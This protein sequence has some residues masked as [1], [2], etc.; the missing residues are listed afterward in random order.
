MVPCRRHVDA[1]TLIQKRW[2]LLDGQSGPLGCPVAA[3][4]TLGTARSQLFQH[5]EIVTSPDQG[6]HMAV[7]VYQQEDNV[8]TSWGDSSAF[9]YD[10]W[11]VRW[12]KDGHYAGQQEINSY[13]D[14]T[15]GFARIQPFA[16]GTY[17]ASV[18]G[19]D[20]GATSSQ[21]RQGWTV[22][23]TVNYV[24]P[25]PLNAGVSATCPGPIIPSGPIR[26]RW[27]DLGGATGPLGCPSPPE[28][29]PRSQRF[30]HGQ[31]VWSP[32][33]GAQMAVAV[34]TER[35]DL[36]ADWGD[37]SPFNYDK[38]LVRWIKNGYE[39]GQQD[40]TDQTR[41]GGQ[42]RIHDPGSGSYVV[43]VEGCD[44]GGVSGSHCNQGWTAPVTLEYAS[45]VSGYNQPAS[46]PCAI[47]TASLIEQRWAAL[48]GQRGPLGCPTGAF[49]PPSPTPFSQT[50]ANGE[51][52]TSL[53]QG[54]NMVV[55]AYQ[56]GDNVVV[57]WG[58]STPFHY[59]KWL[60]RWYIDGHYADQTDITDQS[61]A[62]GVHSMYWNSSNTLTFQIEGCDTS[63]LTGSRCNQGWTTPAS[64]H[65]NADLIDLSANPPATTPQ[66]AADTLPQRAWAVSDYNAC[67]RG[68]ILG[69]INT[70][71]E[72]WTTTAFAML[73]MALAAHQFPGPHGAFQAGDPQAVKVGVNAS[74][75]VPLGCPGDYVDFR[76]EVN[77]AIRNQIITAKAGT[78]AGSPGCQRTGEYDTA[79]RGYITIMF[80]FHAVLDPDVRY[81][82]LHLLNKSGPY[83]AAE[84]DSPCKLQTGETENHLWQ[85]ESSRY[86]T[87]QL[88]FNAS[89][90]EGDIY[91]GYHTARYD[92]AANG[93]NDG[94]VTMKTVI[95]TMLQH[96]L[97][98]DFREYNSNPYQTYTVPSIL[99]LADD[100]TDAD[101]ATG[102]RAVLDYLSAKFAVSDNLL[103]RSVPYRR[104]PSHYTTDLLAANSDALKNDFMVLTGMTQ[105]LRDVTPPYHAGIGTETDMQE[106]AVSSYQ[107]PPLIM[108][109]IMNQAHRHFFERFKHDGVEIYSGEP[110]FLI[111]GGGIWTGASIAAVILGADASDDQGLALPTVLI[112]TQMPIVGAGLPPNT[113]TDVTNF[114][115]IDGVGSSPCH[116][117]CTDSG[118]PNPNRDRVMTCVTQDF[119][120]GINPVIPLSYLSNPACAHEADQ[121]VN[122]HVTGHWTFID[123][124]SSACIGAQPPGTDPLGFSVAVYKASMDGETTCQMFNGG[125]DTG[126][127][128]TYDG[129]NLTYG[130]FE[131][132]GV[133]EGSHGL[134]GGD[135][136]QS[137]WQTVLRNNDG[138]TFDPTGANTYRASDG[139][140]IQFLFNPPN[141][142][143]W[144]WPIVQDP[145]IG[146][147][148]VQQDISG[149]PLAKGNVIASDGHSGLV[150][151]TNADTNQELSL[152]FR[153]A[154]HPQVATRG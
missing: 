66:Q 90:A 51:I 144:V 17:G 15:V 63:T 95:L 61:P 8:I 128:G 56:R 153:D 35:G 45:N 121:T 34:Y 126:C 54:A 109:L 86:L 113:Y 81:R 4:Q 12:D 135:T 10:K 18:E 154:M 119:A 21:C 117:Q 1:N 33:Q 31:I 50:F 83:D 20:N 97:Q 65:F 123:R 125:V 142:N 53:N 77:D 13:V 82:I 136:F 115:R 120:C 84:D 80:R 26:D 78:S 132:R 131:A 7:A 62:G 87:N 32:Q 127:D 138:R 105:I 60:I 88:L 112:P 41:L 43:R 147:T 92:N 6:S 143:K 19:C 145:A 76:T 14:R 118:G 98:N 100:A 24:S 124:Q 30:S 106:M 73:A 23:A 130:F 102:A 42:W 111:S 134:P 47:A 146:I 107:P 40:I 58:D 89:T 49:P 99:N 74:G 64:V 122:D 52:V 85:I 129:T 91:A 152:D 93:M 149:W 22:R 5:G 29:D 48:G 3:G 46:T 69:D 150:T 104:R 114:V 70:T 72:D 27:I 36:V 103:R 39:A 94:G 44:N 75:P 16:S 101:V 148:A 71:G 9:N 137:F 110:E 37:S 57:D 25:Q 79:L 2:H 11:L 141:D 139:R 108:D 67:R 68:R 38:W 116:G 151:I 28:N 96:V 133:S 59:D 55:A 140:E